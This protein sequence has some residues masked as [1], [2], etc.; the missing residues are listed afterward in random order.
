MAFPRRLSA[1]SLP[2]CMN[3]APR[4]NRLAAVSWISVTA[5][6][7]YCG[8]SQSVQGTETSRN[9]LKTPGVWDSV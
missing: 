1:T 4:A 3:K 6:L 9:Y 7:S 8:T 2:C 5:L